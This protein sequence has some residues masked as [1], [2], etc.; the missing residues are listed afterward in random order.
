MPPVEQVQSRLAWMG[1]SDLTYVGAGPPDLR[2]LTMRFR[3]RGPFEG[4]AREWTVGV[5][6]ED[7]S[8]IIVLP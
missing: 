4:Q 3:G 5:A 2:Y 8:E 1:W 7:A 6:R